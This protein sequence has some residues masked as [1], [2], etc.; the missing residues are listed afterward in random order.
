MCDTGLLHSG[1][2]LYWVLNYNRSLKFLFENI[3]LEAL[4]FL[5]SLFCSCV[6]VCL[7]LCSVSVVVLSARV[8]ALCVCVCS[9]LLLFLLFLLP[10]WLLFF[11]CFVTVLAGFC[12]VLLFLPLLCVVVADV[13]AVLW[14]CFSF[15]GLIFFRIIILPH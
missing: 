9:S 11:C 12:C 10:L 3:R 14:L 15:L 6:F 8:F 5:S 4:L 2:S 1:Y 7:C 13:F